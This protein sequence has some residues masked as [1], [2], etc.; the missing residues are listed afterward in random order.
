MEKN[1]KKVTGWDRKVCGELR[2]FFEFY[3]LLA[4]RFSLRLWLFRLRGGRR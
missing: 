1:K 3:P 4:T 2:K